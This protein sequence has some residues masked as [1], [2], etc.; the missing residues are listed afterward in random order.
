[1]GSSHHQPNKC[2]TWLTLSGLK[3]DCLI[4]E[5]PI[6]SRSAV[7][8]WDIRADS[9]APAKQLSA[10]QDRS[11][12]SAVHGRPG[13]VDGWSYWSVDS[14]NPKKKWK[15]CGIWYKIDMVVRCCCSSIISRSPTFLSEVAIF[16]VILA[17]PTWG[18]RQCCNWWCWL[19]S[20]VLPNLSC[21]QKEIRS[22]S[23]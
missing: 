18:A 11:A 10:S 23:W 16:G 13:T 5:S 9:Q 21:N 3:G 12:R 19:S 17:S 14:L 1:M 20:R 6:F 15:R 4:G 7:Q 2:H 22:K 8:P